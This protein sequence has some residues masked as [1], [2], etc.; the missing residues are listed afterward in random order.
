MSTKQRSDPPAFTPLWEQRLIAA[1]NDGDHVAEARLL[2]LYEPMI[3]RITGS[4]Y[5]PGG[6][7]EDLAQEARLGILAAIR[8]W[9]PNRSVPFRCFAWLCAVREARMAVGAARAAKHQ[10]LNRARSLHTPIAEDGVPLQDTLVATG[11]PDDD[12]VAKTLGRERLRAVLDGARAL[13]EL[14]RGALALSAN[15]YR[16][17]DSARVLGVGERAV[18]NALQRA[19]RKLAGPGHP[20]ARDGL[21]GRASRSAILTTR[22][23]RSFAGSDRA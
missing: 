7:R 13:T 12:P 4:L 1:A 15:D 5:L 2:D 3:R 8:A 6:E 18:N 19:R 22:H 14:E 21:K 17:R 16:H 23:G 20:I 10:P 9:D 11:H